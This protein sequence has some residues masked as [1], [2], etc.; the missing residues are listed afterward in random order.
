MHFVNELQQDYE[1]ETECKGEYCG[2]ALKWIYDE[3]YVDMQMPGYALKQLKKYRHKV[4]QRQHTHLQPQPQKYGKAVQEPD[5]ADNSRPLNKED[6]KL[7][8]QVVGSF[9]F[10]GQAVDPIILHVL[11]TITNQQDKPT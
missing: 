8:Q 5:P 3:R 1:I 9:I 11:N 2:I 4:K 6:T 10:Y 7:V